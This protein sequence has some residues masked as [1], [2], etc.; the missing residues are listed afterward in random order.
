MQCLSAEQ[1]RTWL[2]QYGFQGPRAAHGLQRFSLAIPS[3]AGRKTAFARYLCGWLPPEGAVL[4][5]PT[6]WGVWPTAENLHVAVLLRRALGARDPLEEAPGHV[7]EH[8]ERADLEA[9]LAVALYNFWDLTL[10]ASAARCLVRFSHDEWAELFCP[11]E[12]ESA[13]REL[14][15]LWTKGPE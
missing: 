8:D 9:L 2:D 11:A 13:T 4:L 5:L 15:E 3:D 7:F 10:A 12:F 6:V 14:V 1:S